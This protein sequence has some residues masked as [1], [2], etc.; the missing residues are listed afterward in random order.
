MCRPAERSRLKS[1][2]LGLRPACRAHRAPSVAAVPHGA[3]PGPGARPASLGSSASAHVA[4]GKE[5]GIRRAR[6]VF[7]GSICSPPRAAPAVAGPSAGLF[8]ITKAPAPAAPRRPAPAPPQ[9]PAPR[10]RSPGTGGGGAGRGG[11][12]PAGAGETR[13]AER[14]AREGR[15][16]GPCRRTIG[17]GQPA[18][19][20]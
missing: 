11:H 15:G 7:P 20:R 1:P 19:R 6:I 8:C 18:G 14:Q 2:P 13:G 4:G 17:R 12:N 5:G 9:E 3:R 16:L 10:A